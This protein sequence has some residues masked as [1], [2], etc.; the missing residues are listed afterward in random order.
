MDASSSRTSCGAARSRWRVRPSLGASPGGAGVNPFVPR[1]E[2]VEIADRDGVRQ[3][4]RQRQRL[5][6]RRWLVCID[7][8]ADFS[9]PEIHRM[10]RE[11]SRRAGCT[12]RSSPT[13]TSTTSR[14]SGCSSEEAGEKGWPRPRVI[15]HEDVPTRFDALRAHRRLQRRD[16][17]PP[18]RGRGLLADGVPPAG[19]DLPRRSTL[20]VGGERFE[21]HH[22]RG[23]TDDYTWIWVPGRKVLCPGDLIIWCVPNAGNPQKVQRYAAEWV[24]ALREMVGA[25]RRGAAPRARAARG[26][27]PTGSGR[28]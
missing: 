8:G 25:R 4:V 12:R 11:W 1:N 23:E 24:L 9:A 6:D 16:Q 28:S 19:R 2:L 20:E 18:V 22:A 15:A 3:L 7:S 17:H 26:R 10:I 21:L 27:A 14:R 5:R 13:G